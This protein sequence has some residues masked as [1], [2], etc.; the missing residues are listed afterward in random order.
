MLGMIK[1]TIVYKNPH[2]LVTLYKSLVRPHL[3]YR[4][5]AWSPYYQKDKDSFEKVQRRF[6]RMFKE[7]KELDYHDRL[8]SLGLPSLDT[9]R[10][11][12]SR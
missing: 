4:C 11:K 2:I 3:E 12:E 5:S 6:T 1:R 9:R 10:A 7:L 8:Q